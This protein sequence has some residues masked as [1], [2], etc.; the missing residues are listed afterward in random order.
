M[1]ILDE[2][3]KMSTPELDALKERSLRQQEAQMIGQAASSIAPGL[4]GMLIGGTNDFRS[5]QFDRGNQLAESAGKQYLDNQKN[6]KEVELDGQPRYVTGQEALYEKPYVKPTSSLSDGLGKAYAPFQ[7]KHKITGEIQFVRPVGDKLISFTTGLPLEDIQDWQKHERDLYKEE[8][9]ATGGS[10]LNRIDPITGKVET[11]IKT[12]GPG[13]IYK[14][15][16]KGQAENIESGLKDAQRSA[17]EAKSKIKSYETAEGILNSAMKNGPR[18]LSAAIFEI[19]K[20]INKGAGVMTDRDFDKVVG[21]DAQTF[22]TRVQDA[23]DKNLTGE[24]DRYAKTF[25][26]L[27]KYAKL[28]QQKELDSISEN[29]NLGGRT[30]IKPQDIVPALKTDPSA[31]KKYREIEKYIMDQVKKDP[32]KKQKS[33]LFLKKKREELGIR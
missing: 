12:A 23:Y 24:L 3:E 7:V 30:D 29:L 4:I 19:A 14:V 22:M 33:D 8:S 5:R 27:V 15:A 6:L 13:D 28:K 26:N 17:L 18:A 25:I 21:T 20:D 9:L 11:K 1:S 10:R 2:I 31:L 32:T 16:T